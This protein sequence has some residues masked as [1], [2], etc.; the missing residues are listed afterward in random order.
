MSAGRAR[1]GRATWWLVA[2]G[3]ALRIGRYAMHYPLW[4]DEAFLAENLLDRGYLDLLRPLDYGQVCPVLFLWAERSMTA[5]FGFSEWSLRL[6]PLIC[7]VSSVL[8][9]RHA[10]SRVFTGLP[11]LLAVGIFSTSFHPIRHAADVK[12]YASDL[13]ASLI[14]LAL[15]I[16]WWRAPSRV[17]FLWILAAVAPLAVGMSHPS[18]FVAG[19]IALGLAPEAIRSGRRAISAL[20]TFAASASATFV[21]LYLLFTKAQS[22][23]TL[24]PMRAQWG[25]AFP[26]LGDPIALLAWLG[27]VHVGGMFAYPVGG[28]NGGSAATLA[29][30][31]IGAVALS[32]RGG[33]TVVRCVLASFGL[34]LAAA[35]LKRY[36]YGGVAHGSPARVMQYLAPGICLLSGAG[37]AAV[38]E[39]VGDDRRRA[40]LV[41]LVVAALAAAGVVPLLVDLP[42]PYRSIHAQRARAFAREFWPEVGR[43]ATPICLRGDLGVLE[44][45][46][47][48]L[49]VA[50]YLCNRAIYAARR[51]GPI[52]TPGGPLRYIL[53]LAEVDEPRAAAWLDAMKA[54]HRLIRRQDIEANMAEPGA[55]PR[56]ERYH[57]LDF[58]PEG[59][60]PLGVAP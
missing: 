4:W 48:N 17:G 2:L 6:L 25:R 55:T 30:F 9:F 47:T 11:L 22:A 52:P 39:R 45:D 37:A 53:P 38:L 54:R 44:R 57:V 31:A 59:P 1:I 23:A 42:R 18:I 49:N 58:E 60:R 41:A 34:A 29:V 21:A 20:S 13:L 10:A 26:P 8:L 14:L 35:A 36:P 50:V 28:E 40:R 7:A 15:A 33:S 5:V 56:V 3:V 16:E 12:P 46:S 27:E 32:R 19:G 43:D 51:R 24:G